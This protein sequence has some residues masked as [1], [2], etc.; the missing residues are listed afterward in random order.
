[1]NATE[2]KLRNRLDIRNP[3][4]YRCLPSP[5][6]RTVLLQGNKPRAPTDSAILVGNT[7]HEVWYDDPESISMRVSIVLKLNLRGVGVWTANEINY[8]DDARAR[9]QAAEM[10][11]AVCPPWC[12]Y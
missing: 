6:D 3:F 2:T 9:M 5:L 12:N 4:E 8:A 7:Y 1:M 10:W 11:N